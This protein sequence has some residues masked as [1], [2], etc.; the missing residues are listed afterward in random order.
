VITEIEASCLRGV[1]EGRLAGLARITVLVGPNGSGKSTLLE[2]AFIGGTRYPATAVGMIIRRR[3]ATNNG[4]RWLLFGGSSE[5]LGRVS[6]TWDDGQRVAREVGWDELLVVPEMVQQL[7]NDRVPG[8][9][10]AF[11][12]LRT[13]PPAD[14][15]PNTDEPVLSVTGIGANNQYVAGDA[16]RLPDLPYLRFVEPFAPREPLHDLFSR[17]V[18]RGHRAE[19]LDLARGAI[20]DLEDLEILTEDGAPRLFARSATGAVPAT[21]AGDG[22]QTLLRTIFEL[23]G[24]RRGTVLLEEPEAHQHPRSIRQAAAA[25]VEAARR[26]LQIILTTHS[27]DLIDNLLALLEPSEVADPGFMILV[28]SRLE[29]GTLVTTRLSAEDGERARVEISEDLR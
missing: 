24:S 3:W 18:Q 26:G 2:A 27:L 16:E 10:S 5:V 29:G 17:V 25:I 9:Y 19:V 6:V 23:A 8:P 21:L 13:A 12:I 22:L 11:R 20:P 14:T 15:L 1:K 7:T 4:A 28:R